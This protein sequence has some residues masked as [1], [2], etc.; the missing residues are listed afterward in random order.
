MAIR[1]CRIGW[2]PLHFLDDVSL[3]GSVIQAGRLR[4]RAG[5]HLVPT[6]RKIRPTRNGRTMPEMK[7]P[8]ERVPGQVLPRS[9]PRRCVGD[10][11]L[12]R[13]PAWC[14]C[15]RRAA[16]LTQE[17][18]EAGGEHPRPRARRTSPGVKVN[19]SATDFAPLSQLQ[20]IKFK[21]EGLYLDSFGDMPE[22]SPES[23]CPSPCGLSSRSNSSNGAPKRANSSLLPSP[24][25]PFLNASRF[26]SKA[27][28]RR[29]NCACRTGR[30]GGR[31]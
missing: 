27:R 5:H 24:I 10:V 7:D 25:Q 29:R 21:G 28:C 19:T 31:P 2:K 11:R 22:S 20:L 3:I 15:L 12:Y 13:F 14:M 26:D 16:N 9:Q 30:T 18:H 17:H 23:I 4:E 6:V 1:K 8:L